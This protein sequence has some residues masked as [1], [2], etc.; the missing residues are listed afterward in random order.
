MGNSGNRAFII[1]PSYYGIDASIAKA[2]EKNGFEA[3]LVNYRVNASLPEKI[4][5]RAM[6]CSPFLNRALHPCLKTAHALV[7][8]TKYLSL[9][10][11]D[12][13]L[14]HLHRQGRV[15]LS[16]NIVQLQAGAEYPL[17]FLPMGRPLSIPLMQHLVLTSI[18]KTISCW[19]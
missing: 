7:E 15:H 12:W 16:R 13:P 18:E 14:A 10:K 19:A 11:N 6:S 3:T 9:A 1:A 5:R 8:N 17:F 4:L 2:F